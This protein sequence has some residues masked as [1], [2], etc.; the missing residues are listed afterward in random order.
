MDIFVGNLPYSMR[1]ERLKEMFEV[2]GE[3]A[4]ARVICD[5][6]SGRSKGFGFVE[7]PVEA[8]ARKAISEMN[9]K[10]TDGRP[11][12]VNEARQRD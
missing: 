11:I 10:M 1:S 12:S 7:M 3:V 2:Y 5:K 6:I 9:G 8:D 4:H